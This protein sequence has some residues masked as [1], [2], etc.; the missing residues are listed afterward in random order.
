LRIFAAIERLTQSA[1][2]GSAMS[3]PG[4]RYAAIVADRDLSV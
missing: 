4:R 3:L 2:R 1:Q